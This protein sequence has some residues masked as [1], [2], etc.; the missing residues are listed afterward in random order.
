MP[1]KLERQLKEGVPTS[2]KAEEKKAKE[3]KVKA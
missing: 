3:E 2:Q 1:K